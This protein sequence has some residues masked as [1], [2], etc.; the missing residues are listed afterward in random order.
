MNEAETR[1]EL[2]DP[3]LKAS[4]W[5]V[6]DGSKVLREYN[7]TIGKIQTGGGGNILIADLKNKQTFGKVPSLPYDVHKFSKSV[8]NIL[9]AAMNN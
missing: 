5:G 8:K 7:I 1:A 9:T 2:I 3:K 4:G 6:V